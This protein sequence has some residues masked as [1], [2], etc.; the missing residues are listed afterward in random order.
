MTFVDMASYSW[1]QQCKRSEQKKREQ[2]DRHLIESDQRNKF[3]LMKVLK[4]ASETRGS[5]RPKIYKKAKVH[6]FFHIF[7]E[8]IEKS[9]WIFVPKLKISQY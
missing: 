2:S 5:G 9:I 7:H 8:K 6:N 4:S 1:M 3:Y